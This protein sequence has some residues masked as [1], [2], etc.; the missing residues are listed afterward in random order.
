VLRLRKGVY[1]DNNITTMPAQAHSEGNA[2]SSSPSLM[3]IVLHV[4]GEIVWS[5]NGKPPLVVLVVGHARENFRR[6]ILCLI[7]SY[8]YSPRA[9]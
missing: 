9:I 2:A 8:S 3:V 7:Y 6:T 1:R 5:V 4:I